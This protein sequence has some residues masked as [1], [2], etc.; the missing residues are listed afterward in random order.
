MREDRSECTSVVCGL[1][2]VS[3]E[4]KDDLAGNLLCGG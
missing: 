3:K 2:W 4:D 1:V